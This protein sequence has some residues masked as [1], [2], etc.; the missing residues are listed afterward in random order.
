MSGFS[1]KQLRALRRRLERRHVQSRD[2]DGRT[3]NYVEGWFAIAEANAI[4]G[5]DGWDREM[6]HFE[7]LYE[8]S[9]NDRTNCAYLARIRIRV[10]A[11]ENIV[12]REGTGWG[13]A[14]ASVPSEAHER[15]LKSA[16]TDATKRALATFGNRFG[17]GLYDKEQFGVTRRLVSAPSTSLCLYQPEGGIL[18]E[19]VSPEAFCSGLRQLIQNV[20]SIGDVEALMAA[21]KESIAL[22]RKTA[23]DLKTSKDIHYAD[24]LVRLADERICGVASV[25]GSAQRC[26]ESA[27]PR[28]LAVQAVAG[29]AYTPLSQS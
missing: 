6:S 15:A 28:I 23:P 29:G 1:P 21:N 9:R 4:F 13:S 11:G 19:N 14:T 26:N 12:V 25:T 27:E 18:A 8:R 5:F 20:D 3:L 2:V 24:V 7:R 22:L 16:E 17:L 10:R